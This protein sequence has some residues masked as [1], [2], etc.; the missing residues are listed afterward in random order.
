MPQVGIQQLQRRVL[1]GRTAQLLPH[2]DQGGGAAGGHVHP[3]QQL[4]P[5]RLGRVGKAGGGLA[6]RL[7]QPGLGRLAQL[8]RVG[9]KAVGEEAVEAGPVGGIQAT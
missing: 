4:L 9:A 8:V 3:P 1:P 5:R 6:G 2:P 7:G